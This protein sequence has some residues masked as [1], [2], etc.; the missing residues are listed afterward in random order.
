MEVVEV[1]EVAGSARENR[2]PANNLYLNDGRV[3]GLII[4]ADLSWA[5]RRLISVD[6]YNTTH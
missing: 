1:V 5:Y 6:I 3:S 4:N 2:R